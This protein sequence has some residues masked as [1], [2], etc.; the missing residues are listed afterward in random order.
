MFTPPVNMHLHD[1]GQF[2]G[3]ERQFV[4]R[5]YFLR[6]LGLGLGFMCVA[7]VFCVNGA[8]WLAWAALFANGF[9]W[10]HL[11]RWI[12]LRAPSPRKPEQDKRKKRILGKV[13][14]RGEDTGGVR[15]AICGREQ[16]TQ[17][18]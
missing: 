11:A 7:G 5:M 6:T 14:A 18:I 16:P 9:L 12:A 10:S 4:G 1:T 13:C 8:H 2:N 17:R 15:L 3:P